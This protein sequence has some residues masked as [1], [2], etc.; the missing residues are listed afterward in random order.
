M[1][2]YIG[3]LS[4]FNKKNKNYFEKNML[5]EVLSVNKKKN[6]NNVWPIRCDSFEK[7]EFKLARYVIGAMFFIRFFQ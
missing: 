3:R 2:Y 6:L 1:V 4:G 5:R 7:Y